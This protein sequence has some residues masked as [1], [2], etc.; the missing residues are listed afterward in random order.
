MDTIAVQTFSLQRTLPSL[1]VPPLQPTLQKY[2]TSLRPIFYN[3]P[4][5]LAKSTRVVEEFEH[6]IGR[7][8]HA[9]LSE[10]AQNNNNWL[11]GK[12]VFILS[13][14]LIQEYWDREYLDCRTPLPILSSYFFQFDS[15]K[16]NEM[17]GCRRA[18]NLVVRTLEF[19]KLLDRYSFFGFT[20]FDF[21]LVNNSLLICSAIRRY[22]W[23]LIATCSLPV[24]FLAIRPMSFINIPMLLT[25]L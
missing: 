7:I 3:D 1:P 19:K 10:R 9:K 21:I 24:V 25:S 17:S 16:P 22:V 6:G 23:T 20:F 2:L 14:I 4:D 12:V 11:E 8:L 15:C 13:L 5:Q 18:A